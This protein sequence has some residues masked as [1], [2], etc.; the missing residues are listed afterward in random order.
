ML[1]LK[2]YLYTINTQLI[3]GFGVLGP[4]VLPLKCTLGERVARCSVVQVV[5]DYDDA[6]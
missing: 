2:Y 6:K 3:R 5:F 1:H 4:Q